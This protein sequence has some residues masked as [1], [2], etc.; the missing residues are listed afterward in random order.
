MRAVVAWL[1]I[2]LWGCR[3]PSPESEAD[4]PTADA[5]D[6]G[7]LPEDWWSGDDAE[8]GEGGGG[9]GGEDGD[10][11][12]G[13]EGGEGGEDGEGGDEGSYWFGYIEEASA[14]ETVGEVGWMDDGCEWSV[15]LSATATDPCP[16]C[17][18]GF[19]IT[20]G[21]A[22]VE[23]DAGC[24]ELY[25]ELT[26]EGARFT[27]GFDDDLAWVYDDEEGSWEE[28]AEVFYEGAAVGWYAE[29]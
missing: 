10:D 1:A 23:E 8:G 20:I 9:E 5:S 13:G 22:Y 2:G 4:K 21:T 19:V 18:L 16:G 27:V 24:D 14:D 29:L 11:W 15:E 25:E 17:G 26:A 12:E 6:T 28:F 3:S 7:A